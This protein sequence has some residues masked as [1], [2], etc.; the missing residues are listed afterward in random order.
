MDGLERILAPGRELLDRVDAALL[1]GGA[2]AGH[3]IWPLLRRVGALP[4]DVA[5]SVAGLQPVVVESAADQLHA[6]AEAYSRRHAAVGGP[7]EWTGAAAE[8]FGA[9]WGQLGAYLGAD[10]DADE[11]SLSGRLAAS[12]AYLED[13]ASWMRSARAAMAV[14]L[15]TVL[16]SAE[17][18]QLRAGR[19]VAGSLSADALVAAAAIGV[20]IL[21]A[22]ASSCDD[23]AVVAGRWAAGLGEL[24]YW[25]VVEAGGLRPGESTT[26]SL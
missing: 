14:A 7:E 16:G 18:L 15:A 12:A 11:A 26:V 13:V 25:P 2:P 8:A 6:L 24:A 4:G 20:R 3:P 17:A 9:R 21:D 19:S 1:A 22:A 5:G 10:A 23:G